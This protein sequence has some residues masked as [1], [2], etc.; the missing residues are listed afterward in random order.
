MSGG[1]L[2]NVCCVGGGCTSSWAD[3]GTNEDWMNFFWDWRTNASAACPDQPTS[4]DMIVL[5]DYTIAQT[6]TSGG[7]YTTMRNAAALMTWL[8][9]C[10][11]EYAP[12]SRIDVYSDWNGIN[13]D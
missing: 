6:P 10:L 7:Y 8:P 4:A 3:A 9:T 1:R 2:E 11:R 12:G 13:H 5:F